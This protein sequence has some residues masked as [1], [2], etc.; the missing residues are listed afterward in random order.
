MGGRDGVAWSVMGDG[1]MCEDGWGSVG[2]MGIGID[3]SGERVTG[4]GWEGLGW[5]GVCVTISDSA[6]H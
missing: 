2:W 1:A 3:W 6:A 4:L 5:S